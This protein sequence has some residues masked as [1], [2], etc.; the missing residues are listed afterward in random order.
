MT[1][2]TGATEST[3]YRALY[4]Y[5]CFMEGKKIQTKIIITECIFFLLV[6]RLAV[7]LFAMTSLHEQARET[8]VLR[9][10]HL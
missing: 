1:R 7:V 5:F 3:A 2:P 10:V 4:S 6:A 8:A 9:I